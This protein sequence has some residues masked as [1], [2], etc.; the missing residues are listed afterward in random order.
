MTIRIQSLGAAGEVTGSCHLLEVGGRRIL[1]DCGLFQGGRDD[2][3]RNRAPFPFPVESIDAVVLSHA[4]IDHSGRLPLLVDRGYRGPVYTHRATRDLC[5]I[6]LKDAGHLQEKDAEWESRKRARKGL[7]PVGPLYDTRS[8]ARAVRHFRGLRYGEWRRIVPGV[9]VRLRDAGHI[10]GS[11]I[12]ELAL[13]EGGQATTLVYSGDLG[14][15]DAPILRN[16]ETVEGADEVLMESTYGD[17]S[18]RSWDAT[19][20][21]LGSIFRAASE[22]RG[23]IL[24]PAFAVGRSQD[25]LYLFSLH[26][27]DWELER[28]RVFLDSPLAIDATAVYLRHAELYDDE[29]RRLWFER[30]RAGPPL[31]IS[32]TRTP[33]QS[34]S[35][36][37]VRSGAIIMAGSGMCTGGRIRHHLKH[38]VWREEC[39]LVFV[40][41]QAEGTLG[42]RIVDGATWI[43]LWGEEIRV[44]ARVHTVG[45]LSA[46][47]G[48]DGLLDWASAIGGEPRFH[49]V[50]GEPRATEALRREL[51]GRIGRPVDAMR[52]GAWTNLRTRPVKGGKRAA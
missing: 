17:R 12:V 41:Y 46:H 49:L 24:I 51:S 34:M 31:D 7:P 37:R 38:N 43:R 4:H 35:I 25:L 22:S 36:N 50:H 19:L 13:R 47:A 42:R 8:A 1:L 40:G 33:A 9:S 21:E 28:W 14:H 5:R 26:A 30:L 15:R 45:G 27:R 29:A 11:A 10:L 3:E 18:H 2:E 16:P 6:L 32:F 23:N 20:R 48:Q 44:A 39:H 52:P